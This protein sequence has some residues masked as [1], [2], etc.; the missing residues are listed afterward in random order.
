MII[1]VPK[2]TKNNENRVALTP[3][4]TKKLVAQGHTVYIQKDAGLG[5]GFDDHSYKQAG[6]SLKSDSEEVWSAQLILKVKEPI[7]SEYKYFRK[8]MMLFTY[9]HLAANQQLTQ[10]LIH[11]GVTAIAYEMVKSSDGKFPL[12]APMSEV[13]GRLGGLFSAEILAKESGKLISGVVGVEKAR[14][15]V[16]GGGIAGTNAA[17]ILLGVNADV[18]ILDTNLERLRYLE[19][20]F[21]TVKTLFST[22]ETVEASIMESD[23]VIGSV[24]IPGKS[25]PHIVS[26]ELVKKLRKGTVLV[27]IAIDQG[28]CFETSRLTTHD[29]PTFE[30]HGVIHYSVAN[31]PGIVP[32]TA[33]IA[34]TN[35]TSKYILGLANN[36][37]HEVIHK[38]PELVS[39]VSTYK[40]HLTCQSV[41]E[42]LLM[43]VTKMTELL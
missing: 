36:E 21:P 22:D 14:A 25:A 28:G 5:A 3:V 32:K 35:T 6:A 12:L 9:L 8:D 17:Q 1:G 30:K 42:S 20:V 10:E 19:K 38:M 24:L 40:G 11:S 13:A 18:T 27:D 34:L 2:E 33:T 23:I 37:L 7:E 15:T 43:D 41:A 31:M 16:I 4:E 29:N 26:E 39:A